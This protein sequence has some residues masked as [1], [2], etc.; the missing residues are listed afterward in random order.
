MTLFPLFRGACITG[1]GRGYGLE[2]QLEVARRQWDVSLERWTN[3]EQEL[4]YHQK[5]VVRLEI[6]SST[7]KATSHRMAA[8]WIKATNRIALREIVK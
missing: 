4:A 6:Q 3:I 7:A 8:R 5:Q 1:R 2:Q